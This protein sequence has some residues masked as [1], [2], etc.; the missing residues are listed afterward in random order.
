MLETIFISSSVI[1]S[2]SILWRSTL[3]KFPKSR[4][5]IK[6]I[7][8]YFLGTALTCGLCFTYWVAFF[9]VLIFKPFHLEDFELIKNLNY[10]NNLFNFFVSW[11]I[12]GLIA[13]FIRFVFAFLQEKV[14]YMNEVNGHGHHH[15]HSH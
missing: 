15:G 14:N 7:F 12:L 13:I 10:F 2:I 8:P 9:F 11:M 4:S 6:S 3:N 1:A 5:K